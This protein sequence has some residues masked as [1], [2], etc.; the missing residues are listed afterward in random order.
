MLVPKEIS[1][2]IGLDQSDESLSGVVEPAVDE[3]EATIFH[4]AVAQHGKWPV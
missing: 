2:V 1:I 3:W 4:P